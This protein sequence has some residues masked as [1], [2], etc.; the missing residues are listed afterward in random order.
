MINSIDIDIDGIT[1]ERFD[2]LT[3]VSGVLVA[4]VRCSSC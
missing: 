1:V 2:A 4:G 3:A